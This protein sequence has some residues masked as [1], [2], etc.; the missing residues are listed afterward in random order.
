MYTVFVI[1]NLASG[2]STASR[3]LAAR[4]G[5]HIDLDQLAKDLYQPGTAIVANLQ[6]AFGADIV[7]EDGYV[8]TGVLAVRAFASP[9]ATQVLNSIVHPVLLQRL[10]D[11]LV[12]PCGCGVTGPTYPF[13][14]VEISV[15]QSFTDAFPLA[16]EII[17]ITAPLELRCARAVARG[18]R[19]DDFLRRAAAQPSEAE[20]CSLATRVIDNTAADESLFEALDAWLAE[21]GFDDRQLG[22]EALDV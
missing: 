15:A 9:E 11:M 7:D 10:G 3:Y 13:T 5:R 1:G 18:M 6:D 2:K 22:L 19:E 12:E 4:G 14:V 16:D 20:I 21:R 8:R 17:A